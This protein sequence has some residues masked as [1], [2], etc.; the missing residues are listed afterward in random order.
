MQLN[1]KEIA[2][3][4]GYKSLKAAVLRNCVQGQNCF[5][6]GGCNHEYY[7]VVPQTDAALVAMGMT[8]ATLC[9]SKCFHR[10][11]NKFKWIIDRA[12]HY[13]VHTGRSIVDILNEWELNRTYSYL[14]YYQDSKFPKFKK[15][16]AV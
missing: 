1:W 15:R 9:V 4:A 10:Y 3:S 7:R 16:S 8:H 12:Q 11:C 2:Q 14:N 5:N 13:S 6:T